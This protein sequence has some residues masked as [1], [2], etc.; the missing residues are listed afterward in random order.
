MEKPIPIIAFPR[1]LSNA[2]ILKCR[3]RT[4]ATSGKIKVRSQESVSNL[5]SLKIVSF[6]TS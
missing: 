1:T 3:V 6:E 4:L 5:L 2:V